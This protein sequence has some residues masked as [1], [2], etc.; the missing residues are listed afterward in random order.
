MTVE[1]FAW[2]MGETRP[3]QVHASCYQIWDVERRAPEM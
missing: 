2:R 3:L 1:G